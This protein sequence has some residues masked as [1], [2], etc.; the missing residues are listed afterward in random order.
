MKH[1]RERQAEDE[2]ES[3]AV[4]DSQRRAERVDKR[5]RVLLTNAEERKVFEE[6]FD[7]RTLFVLQLMMN[8]GAFSYLNGV[9]S[10]GKESRVYWGIKED[11]SSVAVKIY[12]V[13]SSDF[14]RRLQYIMGDPRF[15]KIRRDSRGIAE[16]WARKE[17][18]NLVQAFEAGVPV[19][20]PESFQGNVL[21]T[22]FIGEN[23]LRAQT[24][25]ESSEI[26]KADYNGVLDATNLLSSKA[27]L[28]HAD[29][30]EYNIFKFQ[31]R[32][33]LFDFGS[34]VSLEH[35]AAL[36]FLRRDLENVNR[37]FSKAGVK[38]VE[39]MKIMKKITGDSIN[40]EEQTVQRQ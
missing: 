36:E 28:V 22:Q 23:G 16:T 27:K 7:R 1:L 34:A 4:R 29:L 35:P 25:Q 2:E 17:Y 20:K 13:S 32:I 11:G 38:T 40:K 24:L 18:T 3:R 5:D 26:T 33:I 8:K 19:P 14:K 37:F 6:V 30:S 21:V 39:E 12:L 31:G 15:R 10:S 9:I